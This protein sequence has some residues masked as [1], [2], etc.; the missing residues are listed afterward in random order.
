MPTA[1]AACPDSGERFMITKPKRRRE[2]R[3]LHDQETWPERDG[4][5]VEFRFNV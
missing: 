4:D 2:T 3:D 5:V 1:A